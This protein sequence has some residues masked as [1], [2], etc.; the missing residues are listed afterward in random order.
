MAALSPSDVWVVGETETNDS[1]GIV[2]HWNGTR[3]S[4][5]RLVRRNRLWDVAGLGSHV[6]AVGDSGGVTLGPSVKRWSGG[7]GGMSIS[8]VSPTGVWLLN[9][10]R[11]DPWDGRQWTS[12]ALPLPSS[13]VDG[14]WYA[15]S[16][17][18]GDEVWVVGQF[19]PLWGPLALGPALI[20]HR[21][22]RS[23]DRRP[24]SAAEGLTGVQALS[25]T[26]VWAVGDRGGG[27]LEDSREVAIHWDG[28]RWTNLDPPTK[29]GRT[30]EALS[31]LN[32]EDV[33]AVGSTFHEPHS[34]RANVRTSCRTLRLLRL[35][36]SDDR[37]GPLGLPTR[38][39]ARRQIHQAG[40]VSPCA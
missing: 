31:V 5:V 37:E 16:A 11:V 6:V 10:G 17:V 14:G 34:S 40:R 29:K 39:W 30:F 20:G 12:H 18:A 38:P 26:D 21:N 15:I 25:P 1:D 36:I 13:A 2:A 9:W 8:V 23:W 7:A 4:L 27:G 33:W 19:V 28:N 24:Y 3:W 32:D 22:G 35:D